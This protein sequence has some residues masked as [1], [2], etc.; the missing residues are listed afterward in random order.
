M[1]ADR[2]VAAVTPVMARPP[3]ISVAIVI[4][5]TSRG[6]V[7]VIKEFLINDAIVGRCRWFR[8]QAD[9]DKTCRRLCGFLEVWKRDR[10]TGLWNVV[11][12][13]IGLCRFVEL[14]DRP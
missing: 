12:G 2:L 6:P 11:R 10:L 7:F 5:L 13:D 4:R 1:R 14:I 9:G 3:L 8:T